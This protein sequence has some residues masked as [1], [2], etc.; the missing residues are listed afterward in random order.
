MCIITFSLFFLFFQHN[1]VFFLQH[2]VNVHSDA[3]CL[4]Q[5]F[6]PQTSYNIPYYRPHMDESVRGQGL[7]SPQEVGLSGYFI[8]ICTTVTATHFRHAFGRITIAA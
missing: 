3:L 6:D 4:K 2:L 5:A 1:T 7:P 8:V